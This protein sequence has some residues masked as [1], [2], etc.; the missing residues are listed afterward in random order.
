MVNLC[1]VKYKRPLTDK[2]KAL[3]AKC[4]P[5][6]RLDAVS[7]I[8]NTAQA[9]RALIG[10]AL[11]AYMLNHYMGIPFANQIYEKSPQGKPFLVGYPNAHFNISHSGKYV[12][13]AVSDRPVGVDVEQ[14]IAYKPRIAKRLFSL[15][16]QEKIA[17]SKDKDMAFTQC[18]AENEANLKRIGCGF[19]CK[20]PCDDPIAQIILAEDAIIGLSCI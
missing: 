4:I 17:N 2:E 9:D 7:Q 16:V 3:L 15:A 20:F 10:S 13:C 19:Q 12:V 8:K 11:A 14:R 5:P 18:W 6:Q 1:L